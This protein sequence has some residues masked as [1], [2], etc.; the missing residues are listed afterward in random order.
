MCEKLFL[1]K[2]MAR[3]DKITAAVEIL[4]YNTNKSIFIAVMNL[5]CGPIWRA[6]VNH[7]LIYFED[8]RGANDSA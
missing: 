3:S 5:K 2:S 4:A 6:G 1:C 8:I 7:M